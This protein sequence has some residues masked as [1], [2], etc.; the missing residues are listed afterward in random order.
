MCA[1][2][3]PG[4][5]AE[6]KYTSFYYWG[7]PM[8]SPLCVCIELGPPEAHSLKCNGIAPNVNQPGIPY[9]AQ[10]HDRQGTNNY[11]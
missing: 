6:R 7:M 10:D 1:G 2:A 4:M 5:D 8:A 3:R 11:L 9:L